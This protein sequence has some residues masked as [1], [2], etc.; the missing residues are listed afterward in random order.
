MDDIAKLI[1][2][3]EEKPE[4]KQYLFIRGFLLT[5]KVLNMDGF[6]FY[7]N[8]NCVKLGQYYACIHNTLKLHFV[9]KII[10]GE[11][12]YFILFGHAYNP[13]TME[14]REEPILER[15]AEAY[16]RSDYLNRIDELTGVFVFCILKG[17]Q[18]EFLTDPSGIQSACWASIDGSFYL[19]SH[20][21]LIGDLCHLNMGSLQKELIN[22]KWYYRVMGPY[23]PAD[24]TSFDQVKR[25]VPDTYYTYSNGKLNHKRFY[26]LKEIEICMSKAEYRKTIKDAA[27][28]LKNNFELVT[29]KWVN[30]Q[31]SLTGG[32]DSNTTFAAA[33]G[34]YDRIKCFSYLSDP[35]EEIDVES[36]KVIADHFSVPHKTFLIP[37]S[38]ENLRNYREFKA[39]IDH[40]NAYIARGRENEYRKRVYLIQHLDADVEVKSWVSETIRAYWYKHY[41]RNKMP[42]LS[43]KLY[44]NLYKIFLTNRK[45]AHRMDK[46]FEKFI[47]EYEYEIV[48]KTYPSAD[49]HF[50]EVTWGSWGGL[51]ISEMKIYSDITIIYNNRRFL[52]LMFRVP[53]KMRINDKHHL[54]LKRILNKELYD[55]NI[56]VVNMHETKMRA[57]LLNVIFTINMFLPF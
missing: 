15:I 33:K 24:M 55:M 27:S 54:D 44:R 53:L 36:A 6:P 8:W 1:G 16:G 43:P 7:G 19:S 13:F 29:K 42:S 9:Y 37:D 18:V 12:Y 46:V 56:R 52:D 49:M 21:Q 31:I 23:L 32:I 35:K 10:D 17:N 11:D 22:Y 41:G 2:M 20:P 45:L 51:N 38:E 4:L 3:L 47:K 26:P 48:P 57:F 50:H 5:D 40:N 30:P 34:Y 39:I 28:I 25:V 14:W